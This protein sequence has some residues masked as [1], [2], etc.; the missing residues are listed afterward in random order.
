MIARRQFTPAKNG[1]LRTSVVREGLVTLTGSN[2]LAQILNQFLYW[3]E[4]VSDIDRYLCEEWE[5]SK[6]SGLSFQPAL[7]H[8]WIYKAARELKDEIMLDESEQII[9]KDIKQLVEWGYLHER[10]NPAHKWDRTR[11]YRVDLLRI[12]EDLDELGYALDEYPL[13]KR[14]KQANQG[15]LQN[16]ESI[17]RYRESKQSSGEAIPETTVKTTTKK[18]NN[19]RANDARAEPPQAMLPDT[20]SLDELGEIFADEFERITDSLEGE[21]RQVVYAQESLLNDSP[22]GK[23]VS[24]IRTSSYSAPVAPRATAKSKQPNPNT[25]PIL[26]AYFSLL[27]YKPTNAKKEAKAAKAL[28]D[29]GYTPEQVSAAYRRMKA[30]TFWQLKHLSLA[31]V[32][33]N[34]GALLPVLSPPGNGQRASSRDGYIFLNV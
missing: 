20:L 13:F 6:Q 23:D 17:N 1:K 28:A 7:T 21:Q 32:H 19:L 27:T 29:D 3:S 26:D 24:V 31:K 18:E 2:R 33:E 16:G 12:Q 8:G 25:K 34:I 10:D 15:N 9:R 4:R 11:Q 30:E 22:L 5:R 14:D